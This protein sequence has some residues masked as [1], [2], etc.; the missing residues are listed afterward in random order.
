MKISVSYAHPEKPAWMR[1]DVDE[2][3]TLRA[4]IQEANARPGFDQ[5]NFDIPGGGI[6]TITIPNAGPLLPDVKG[7]V[8]INAISQPGWSGSPMSPVHRRA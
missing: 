4:A 1:L 5:I 8:D 3:C 6:R 7:D 2:G